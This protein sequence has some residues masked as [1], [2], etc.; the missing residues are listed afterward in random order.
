MGT[1][2][3]NQDRGGIGGG[4][5]TDDRGGPLSLAS[6]FGR[7]EQGIVAVLT[8]VVAI[9]ATLSTWHL[10]LLV[11]R[12]LLAGRLDPADHEVL[13]AIFGTIFTVLIALE[14]RH[15]LLTAS[16][17]R[18][19]VVRV[20]SVVLIAMLAT[21]RKFIVM[22][23]SAVQVGETLAVV[24]AMLA[25]GVVYWL[26]RTQDQKLGVQGFGDRGQDRRRAP[27]AA[28]EGR[29]PPGDRLQAR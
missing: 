8:V 5:G 9:V 29:P 4:G 3:D 6:L 28:G 21:V 25:L 22:D 15:S 18:A 27:V 12:L 7:L 16:S 2:A 11:A 10:I 14:F 20:R 1:R 24:A 26:I 17:E 23:L 13:Q 19:G